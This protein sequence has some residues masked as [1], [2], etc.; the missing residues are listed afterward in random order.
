MKGQLA[1]RLILN[2]LKDEW[3]YSKIKKTKKVL[4]KLLGFMIYYLS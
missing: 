3:I 4:A 1:P 2:E